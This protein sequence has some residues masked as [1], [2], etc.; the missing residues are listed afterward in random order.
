MPITEVMTQK[1]FFDYEA[2]YEGKSSE[3]TP[4]QIDEKVANKIVQLP[5]K[6]TR[7]LIA[8]E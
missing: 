6:F 7:Y 2:K 4:A 5:K 3:I 1:D 8:G